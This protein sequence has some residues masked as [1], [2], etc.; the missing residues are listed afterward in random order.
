MK[1]PWL[2]ALTVTL[3]SM[4]ELLDVTIVNVAIPSLM[5]SY[6]ASVDE[7]SWVSTG[8]IVA[9]VVILPAS[10][11]LSA[12][13]GRRAYYLV[14]SAVFV[15]ASLGCALSVELWQMVLCRVVQGLAGGGLLGISQAIIYDVFP[16]EKV[17]AGMAVYG[18][19]VMMGPTLG[20]SVGGYLIDA[21]SWHWIFLINLPI[22]ALALLLAWL[23]V[24]DSRHERRPQSIDYLGFILLALGVGSLQ[25]LLE[26]GE[27]WDW[28]ESDLTVLCLVLSALGLVG[29]CYWER[30]VANPIVNLSLFANREFLLG[31]I[32]AFCVGFGLYS[33]LFMV[34]LLL[35]TLLEQSAYQ[36]GL[37]IFP[38]A[39]A[40]AVSTLV[41]GKLSQE[42]R[43]DERVFICLGILIYG[44][45]MYLHTQ[46]TLQSNPDTLFWPLVIRGF[47]LGMIFVPLTNLAMRQ[48]PQG[49]IS[50][51]SGVLN[52]MRQL[53]GSVGI[54]IAATLL[55]RFSWSRYR[56][57][58]EHVDETRL[59]AGGWEVANLD[60]RRLS[61]DLLDPG[62]A[63]TLL[64]FLEARDQ[65]QMLGFSMLFGLLGAVMLVGVPMVL[66]MRNPRTPKPQ[67]AKESATCP[68]TAL[69]S[70]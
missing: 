57:L 9:N 35:Q 16:K 61:T 43:I 29:F 58:S 54:A 8:Y 4:M 69:E 12:W 46:F 42:N 45:A 67:P 64:A 33:T 48:L 70:A 41:I 10:G 37:V 39:L 19:G 21:F 6:G 55:T 56:Q 44:Y 31:S 13:F 40:S 30:R 18:V 24:D 32:C 22:G 3:I 60:P 2:V 68:D 23:C 28:L 49:L 38:G 14:S 62:Q 11:W 52:L 20:P 50:V 63:N 65:A 59:L 36:S 1:S 26:R 47:G 51:G 17:S 25:I 34:P 5:G 66:M 27:H 15:V 53:G 7:I